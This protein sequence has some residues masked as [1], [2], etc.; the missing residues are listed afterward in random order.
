M[1]SNLTEDEIVREYSTGP[2][3]PGA[4]RYINKNGTRMEAYDSAQGGIKKYKETN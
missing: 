4:Y 3:K 1:W 2:P